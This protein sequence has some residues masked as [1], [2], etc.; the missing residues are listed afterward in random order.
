MEKETLKL[1][2]KFEKNLQALFKV[3]APLATLLFELTTHKK[4][5]VFQ[6]KD[7]LDINILDTSTNS[8]F[9]VAPKE[10]VLSYVKENVD[11]ETLPFRYFLG[12][13]NGIVIN[14]LLKSPQLKRILVIEPDIE[15][16]YI[17]LHLFDM[18]EYIIN[19]KIV[20]EL[21][22]NLDYTRAVFY[23]SHSEGKIYAKLFEI[24]T[25]TPYYNEHYLDEIKQAS[26]IMADAFYSVIIGHGN[27][28]I[29]SLMGVEHHIQNLPLM[30]KNTKI[31]DFVGKKFCNTAIVVSTGPS[32]S[33]QIPLLKKIQN[34]VT[35]F[36][37]DASFPIL[38]K[39]GI[40]P[41]FVTIL[42]R[43]PE[44]A[45][46]FET[47]TKEFQSDVN[48]IIVSIAHKKV[49]DAIKHGNKVIQMRPH[50]YTQYFELDDFGYV[51]VGMSAANLA[52]E[53]AIALKI[54]NI[55]LI[56]QDLA[57][58]EDNTSHAEG[59]LYGEN[60]ENIHGHEIYVEKYGGNGKIRTTEYWVLFKNYFERAIID[61]KSYA[62][63]INC[64]EGGAR[65]PQTVELSFKD[66]IE[67]V[68]DTKVIKEP[69]FTPPTSLDEQKLLTEQFIEK[70]NFWIKDSVER[71]E[72][73]EEVF[74]IVQ[75]KSEDF[76]DKLKKDKLNL[77]SKDSLI[78]IIEEID[79][80][81][82]YFEDKQF[83][84]L[85]V[86]S[87]QTYIL[88]L[89]L[90][91]VLTQIRKTSTEE[92]LVVKMVDWIMQHRYWLFSLA[93]GIQAVRDTIIQATLT[94]DKNLQSKLIIPNKKEIPIDK[95][96]FNELKAIVEKE[97]EKLN[98]EI[99]V[100]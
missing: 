83:S 100:K 49:I 52:H 48:F 39:H 59:H 22:K 84:E 73:I 34:Y 20:I 62:T 19:G 14:A 3:N 40:K 77:L 61:S 44:T 23:L 80:I 37:V 7:P 25:N 65:I 4:Y 96:K 32:L 55:I 43:I 93:G 12:F 56:G 70:I 63:T 21:L 90:D 41:D 8:F 76:H 38:E 17:V 31:R 15:I 1:D 85:Y 10:N 11:K 51:G 5:E 9:Y 86:D 53:F 71:Q 46:F 94:W 82:E 68:I 75:N 98:T 36:C 58:G 78:P 28:A 24:E 2:P 64:T 66:A 42:E 18:A 16:L 88:H 57:F 79:S 87:I 72:K 69:I 50:G 95:K 92:E 97:Q 45:K 67:K 54:P 13:G 60:E 27:S 6:G 29:D 99:I 33:K 30:I 89:E 74:M 26:K 91:L 47:N 81:K 35:I